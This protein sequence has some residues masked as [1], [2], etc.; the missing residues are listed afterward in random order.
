MLV[1]IA[2]YGHQELMRDTISDHQWPSRGNQKSPKLRQGSGE[3]LGDTQCGT[4]SAHQS[5]SGL[6]SHLGLRVRGT[7]LPKRL[8]ARG[9]QPITG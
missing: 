4:I 2:Q 1:R 3:A 8:E 5:H 7:E 6:P 9:P